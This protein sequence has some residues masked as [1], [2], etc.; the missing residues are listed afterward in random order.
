MATQICAKMTRAA[1]SGAT[2]VALFCGSPWP[3]AAVGTG[4]CVDPKASVSGPTTTYL[5]WGSA[6][7]PLVVK[8]N[9]AFGYTL[10]VNIK[11]LTGG[12]VISANDVSI[13]LQTTLSKGVV[14]TKTI[15]R[16]ASAT[17]TL[18]TNET[19]DL[20]NVKLSTWQPLGSPKVT[21][22]YTLVTRTAG[23]CK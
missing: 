10:T 18:R 5:A 4:A 8:T 11:S 16:V 14:T 22:S 12:V 2:V 20:I 7:M 19:G 13:A 15:G 9:A 21:I 1:L 17:S 6:S 3:A 23:S